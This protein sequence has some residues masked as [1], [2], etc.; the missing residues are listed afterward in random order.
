MRQ[1]D[2]GIR[3]FFSSQMD[4]TDRVRAQAR[5]L[6]EKALAEDEARWR[7]AELRSSIDSQRLLQHEVDHRVKNNMAMIGSI[8]R[9]QLREVPTRAP[10][11]CCGR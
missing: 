11:S 10:P 7:A 1:D 6:R 4:V 8:P 9:L 3:F 5:I 2:G